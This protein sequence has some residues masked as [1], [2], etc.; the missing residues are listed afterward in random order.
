MDRSEFITLTSSDNFDITV[1]RGIAEH[2]LLLKNMLSYLGETSRSHSHSKYWLSGRLLILIDVGQQK[3]PREG[4]R[5]VWSS[6]VRRLQHRRRKTLDGKRILSLKKNILMLIKKRFLG[7]LGG[8]LS[9]IEK[10]LDLG[11]NAVA[12]MIKGKS[13]KEIRRIFNIPNDF[14]PEEEEERSGMQMSGPKSRVAC[15]DRPGHFL[16][17]LFGTV[18]RYQIG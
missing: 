4:H 13:V 7:Y 16:A 2:S 6:T 10:L 15:I 9:E 17:E 1:E 18:F 14:T 3:D 5:L 12:N 8:K 11:C